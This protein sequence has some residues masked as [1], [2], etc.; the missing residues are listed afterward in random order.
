MKEVSQKDVGKVKTKKMRIV[1][2]E[3]EKIILRK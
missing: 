2:E 3:K 1:F